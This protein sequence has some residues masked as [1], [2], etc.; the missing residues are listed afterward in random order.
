MG[1][2]LPGSDILY[3]FLSIRAIRAME[4]FVVGISKDGLADEL[5][6]NFKMVVWPTDQ[7]GPMSVQ[8]PMAS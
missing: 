4:I 2:I 6:I 8:L 7:C 3:Q 5:G 1:D